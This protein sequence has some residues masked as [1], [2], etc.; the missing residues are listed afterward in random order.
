VARKVTVSNPTFISRCLPYGANRIASP[1]DAEAA[2]SLA[3][4][5]EGDRAIWA[6]ALYAGLRRGELLALGWQD[7]DL[8][9]GL[10]RVQQSWAR[11]HPRAQLAATGRE[12]VTMPGENGAI[13]LACRHDKSS[14]ALRRHM[15]RPDRPGERRGGGHICIGSAQTCRPP[16]EPCNRRRARLGHARPHDR[17]RLPGG[18]HA[19]EPYGD[20]ALVRSYIDAGACLSRDA[21]ARSTRRGRSSS[22]QTS[23]PTAGARRLLLGRK[24]E[25]R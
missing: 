4:L 19:D 24:L 11:V 15:D 17:I 22:W 7:V 10:I 16:C 13:A 9:A 25:R 3:A 6:T 12:L 5:Y 21:S 20:Q 2:A 1:S 23:V 8:K 14:R 18:A